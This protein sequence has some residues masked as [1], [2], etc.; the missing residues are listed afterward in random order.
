VIDHRKRVRDARRHEGRR[1]RDEVREALTAER[2]RPVQWLVRAGF[3]ARGLTY[4]VIG[5]IAIALALG[6]GRQAG[7]PD[8]Q[9]ALALIARAPLGKVV[10]VVVSVG[11]LAYALWKLGLAILGTGPEGGG[12]RK[13]SDRVGNAIGGLAY[14]SLFVVSVRVLLGQPGNQS[15]EERRTTAGVLGW[16]EGRLLVATAGACLI[17]V[18]IY[19]VYSALRGSFLDD[20]KLSEMNA[21]QRRL[22]LR[23]GRIGLTARALVFSLI[24]YFL[25]RTAISFRPSTGIGVDG[26]L[27]KL[28]RQPLGAALLIAVAVGLLM[29][30]AFSFFEARYQRL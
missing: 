27:A 29:F 10:L 5:G 3:V 28:H 24:G 11:L 12:G 26:A 20:N 15:Q 16:P 19:Q 18:G 30:A 8:Q 17:G 9:G 25:I 6:V 7:T 21:P 14:L 2:S 22:F 13:L 23:V 1:A 4:G